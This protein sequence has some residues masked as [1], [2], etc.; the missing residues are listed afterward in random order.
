M[1]LYE[2]ITDLTV[3]GAGDVIRRRRYGVIETAGGDLVAV[4]LRPYPK[5]AT[6]PEVM[7]WGDWRH[8]RWPADRC[9]LY[10]NQPWRFPNFLALPYILTGR[11]TKL[12][13][14]YTALEVL[15]EIARI[16][17][18]DAILADVLN[19]RISDRFLARLRWQKHKP[20]RWHRHFIKRFYGEYGPT[21]WAPIKQ[22]A[23]FASAM[24]R[25]PKTAGSKTIELT[26]P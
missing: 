19:V 10:F 12:A 1:P 7:F 5:W 13:T 15:D 3:P 14:V 8:R 20:S 24:D 6:L 21:R 23:D 18:S 9:L 26:A 25:F 2:T 16:K 4:Q 11:G 22:A 17:R